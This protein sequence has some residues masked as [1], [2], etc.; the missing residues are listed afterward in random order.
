MLQLVKT[1][2]HL[3]RQDRQQL[4]MQHVFVASKLELSCLVVSLCILLQVHLDRHWLCIHSCQAYLALKVRSKLGCLEQNKAHAK[5]SEERYATNC[6]SSND[7]Q[8][9]FIPRL[10]TQGKP[11]LW[12]S[13]LEAEDHADDVEH[14]QDYLDPLDTEG[15][16][17]DD[18]DQQPAQ[19]SMRNTSAQRAQQGASSSK[20]KEGQGAD[21]SSEEEAAEPSQQQDDTSDSEEEETFRAGNQH[22]EPSPTRIRNQLPGPKGESHSGDVGPGVKLMGGYDM[23]KRY[24]FLFTCIT[25][26]FYLGCRQSQHSAPGQSCNDF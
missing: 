1:H 13:V 11:A 10:Y 16:A 20:E 21:S 6:K 5:C 12:N 2:M 25:L 19:H 17:E 22:L 15:T 4:G 3:G 14:F 9:P 24:A 23:R 7:Q 18:E 8:H 26:H